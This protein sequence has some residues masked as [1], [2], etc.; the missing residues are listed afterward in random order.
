M[1]TENWLNLIIVSNNLLF[2]GVTNYAIFKPTF[3]FY[4]KVENKPNNINYN[5]HDNS[6]NYL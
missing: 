3:L 5:L 6:C 4:N 2:R 1:N